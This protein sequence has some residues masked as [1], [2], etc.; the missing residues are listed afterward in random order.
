MKLAVIVTE[1]PKTTE[2]FILRDLMVFLDQGVDL[3]IYHLAPWRQ[4]Q[5]LH[6]FA[7]PLAERARHVGLGSSAALTGPLKFPGAAARM[8]AA[9]LRHQG[10]EP[11]MAAK[12]LALLPAALGIADELRDWGADHVHAEFAGHPATAA[13]I[14]NAAVGIPYSV[15]CR[16]HDIFRSQ[17]LL[18]QKFAA[19]TAVR[20]VSHFTRD[21]LAR[22]VRGVGVQDI[23]VIHSS[24]DVATIPAL[25]PAPRDDGFRILYVGALQQRKGVDV[26]LRAL[27]GFDRPDWHLTLAGQGPEQARLESLTKS[28]GL[29]DRVSF[30]GAQPY[31]KIAALYAKAHVCVAPSIIGPKGRTEGIPNVM[32]EALAH[33]RP[34]ISTRVSGIP[35]LIRDGETGLMTDPGDVEA[36]RQALVTLH[37]QPDRALALAKAGRAHVADEFD[38]RRNAARQLEMFARQGTIGGRPAFD[39]GAGTA[40]VLAAAG[41]AS[42]DGSVTPLSGTDARAVPATQAG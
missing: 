40:P 16:A 34:A 31:E 7:A 32:I 3:R 20:S 38:L 2:T 15:S 23:D 29:T 21:F 13:W 6:A 30:L 39:A 18:A 17:R 25:P 9:I 4:N 26:L 41:S 28:L 14:V 1:F 19:A 24:V 22:K 8:T 11:A 42:P 35:E 27:A 37:D 36:L 33:Q 5:I 10:P 12:S